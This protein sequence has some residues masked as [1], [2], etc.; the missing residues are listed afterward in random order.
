MQ[1]F[2]QGLISTE[3][4]PPLAITSFY[5]LIYQKYYARANHIRDNISVNRRG[6]PQPKNPH[7]WS[8]NKNQE[9][10]ISPFIYRA[11]PNFISLCNFFGNFSIDLHCIIHKGQGMILKRQNKEKRI[12]RSSI[13]KLYPAKL[14]KY[15]VKFDFF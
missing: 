9:N 6:Q 5:S 2:R 4:H 12:Q 1:Y 11:I 15:T 13:R 14:E 3:R 8:D 7:C 10:I